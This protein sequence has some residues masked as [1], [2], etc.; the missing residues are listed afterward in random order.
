M[1][2]ERF[3][4]ERWMT[5]WETKTPYDIAESG[6][7]PQTVRDLLSF[8]P[9]EERERTLSR[10]LDLR[11]G[12]SEAPGTEELRKAIAATYRDAGPDEILVTTGAIEA[13]FLLF[14]GLLEP[15]DHVVAVYPAYQ[16]LYSVPRAIG[17]DVSLWELKPE[18]GFRYD[19]D[20]LERLVTPRTRLIV[21]NT[22][23]NPTGAML[24]RRDLE[25]I[26]ALAA[27]VG[28]RV[29]S[30]EA[31]RWLE[32]PGGEP[33][34]PPM[35]D[36]APTAVSVGTL[37]KPFGLPGLRIGWMAAPADLAAKCWAMRDYVSL[38]PGKLNDALAVVAFRHREKIVARTREIVSAN[39]AAA[40]D[41]FARHADTVSWTPPRGGLLALMK[42]ALDIPSLDLSNLLAERY[43]VMLAPGSAFGVEGYLR[44]GIGQEPKTF[45]EGLR[46]TAECFAAL[47]VRGPAAP[48]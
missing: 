16:Q 19:L 43:G 48:A 20:R 4:L 3:A 26:D 41:W 29:L 7:F 18:E 8:E 1:K 9:A 25:R 40:K 27:S 35:R 23:H 38:S 13:N 21:V 47:R 10:L 11:L 14:N 44:I 42:Y 5:A 17:C 37:S 12:Y 33:L 2:L 24:A 6:I 32:I 22:P 34:A 39:L 45:A 30:D 28:A 46:R 15:G 36:F 31:Y